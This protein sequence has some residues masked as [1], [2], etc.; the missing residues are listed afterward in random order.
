MADQRVRFAEGAGNNNP[1]AIV[2]ILKPPR[3]LFHA[4]APLSTDG[5]D[6]WAFTNT[7][8]G[9]Y[10]VKDNGVWI[11]K[12]NYG[13][14]SVPGTITGGANVG[15][16]VPVFKDV[17][18]TDLRFR[19]LSSLDG[20]VYI[21]Q[22]A[23]DIDF[24]VPAP[25]GFL[26]SAANVGTG[27]G[28]YKNQVADQIRFK[29]L[30][31]TS[32]DLT[33]TQNGTDHVDLSI[34]NAA[35]VTSASNVGTGANVFAGLVG[36]DLRFKT[37]TSSS[38]KI[39]LTQNPTT[40]DF[41]VNLT[42]SDVGLN[43]VENVKIGYASISPGVTADINSGFIVGSLWS[44][45]GA[46]QILYVCTDNTAGAAVWSVV[47]NS[48]T[49]FPV[50]YEKDY[51]QQRISSGF[52]QFIGGIGPTALLPPSGYTAGFARGSW[53]IN[54]TNGFGAVGLRRNSATDGQN[55]N[56]F[57]ITVNMDVSA[58]NHSTNDREFSIVTYYDSLSGTIV[59]SGGLVVL[60]FSSPTKT[61]NASVSRQFIYRAST[62]GAVTFYL[63]LIYPNYNVTGGFNLT[64]N[65]ITMTV[66]QL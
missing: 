38:S 44:Q 4:R 1:Y 9:D 13:G 34:T 52:S 18:G 45:V 59:G 65:D 64:V 53:S 36:T 32:G 20:S 42:S 14:G 17:S 51:A 43:F 23:D 19:T 62:A 5:E 6:E 29:S 55:N 28:I 27:V 2:S 54:Q 15:L 61:V 50:V 63:G 40:V 33:I 37:L 31:S 11:L 8:T 49:P 39:T 48:A 46:S 26:V 56:A 22:S 24:Q 47:Y 10:Y 16:G 3:F 21:T 35:T 66:S 30:I 12:Y 25:S 60:P 7:L 41:G 58:T 57:L